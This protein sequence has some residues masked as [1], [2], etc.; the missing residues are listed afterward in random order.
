MPQMID[1]APKSNQAVRVI[2]P[3]V[4]VTVD[5]T[6]SEYGAVLPTTI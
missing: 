1:I 2:C 4:A 6:A 3:G 5:P